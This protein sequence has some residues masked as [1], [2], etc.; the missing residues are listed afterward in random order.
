MAVS[1]IK[2][3]ELHARMRA[4]GVSGRDHVAFRC[5]VCAT[6]QSMASLRRAGA[7][8]DK[9][10]A[11]I[12]FSCEGRFSGAGPWPAKADRSAKSQARRRVRGCD[13]TL[14]GLLTIH[15][16]EVETDDGNVHPSFE[17]A[18]PEEAK[19]LEASLTVPA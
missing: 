12:G 1:K 6:V 14:G 7:P 16:L 17:V 4:Q 19:A 13:W 8:D 9:V 5:P 3:S 15:T 11:Y 2:V 10:E 18:S